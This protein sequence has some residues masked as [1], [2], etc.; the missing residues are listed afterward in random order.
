MNQLQFL[1]PALVSPV[2]A[3]GGHDATGR[4]VTYARALRLIEEGTVD[5]AP[6]ITHRYPSLASVPGAFAG[7]HRAPEYVKGVVAL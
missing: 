4:P 1:E 6:I 2:G 7:D 3:S 5:V